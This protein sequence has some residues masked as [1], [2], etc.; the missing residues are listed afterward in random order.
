MTSSLA[1]LWANGD[2]ITF[3]GIRPNPLPKSLQQGVEE[4]LG[5]DLQR[6]WIKQRRQD[7]PR[8]ASPAPVRPVKRIPQPSQRLGYPHGGQSGVIDA[9]VALILDRRAGGAVPTHESVRLAHVAHLV[10]GRVVDEER[11]AWGLA[12]ERIPGCQPNRQRMSEDEHRVVEHAGDVPARRTRLCTAAARVAAAAHLGH[13]KDEIFGRIPPTA[14]PAIFS[15]GAD[16]GPSANAR[17]G[18]GVDGRTDAVERRLARQ[19]VGQEGTLGTEEVRHDNDPA[20]L[21][22]GLDN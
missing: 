17:Q 11:Y 9:R 13:H 19:L 6:H 1:N 12:A 18:P 20:M 10:L 7:S 21:E 2:T 5:Q 8:H 15:S 3:F 16:L 22:R 14:A 4:H